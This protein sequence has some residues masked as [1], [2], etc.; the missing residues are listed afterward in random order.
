MKIKKIIKKIIKKNSELY[1]L[2]IKV[3]EL[4]ERTK[5]FFL[6]NYNDRLRRKY[7]SKQYK[8]YIGKK[9]DWNKLETYTEKMQWVKLYDEDRQKSILS[10][11]IEVRKWVENKIGAEYLIPLLGTWEKPNQIDFESLPAK[12][13]LKTNNASGT[14]IIV[15]DSSQINTKIVCAKLTRW[16]NVK[17]YYL[18]GF[19]MHYS[20]IKPLI[21]AEEYIEHGENDLQDYKFLC[22]NGK[23]YYCWVD[24]GRYHDHKRNMYDMDWNLQSWNE[25]N[26]R[27]YGN[28]DEPIEKPQN[29]EEMVYIVEKL[30]EGFSHVR[31][32]LYNV[33]GRVLFGEMTFTN[34]SGYGKIVPEEYDY[35]LGKIWDL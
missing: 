34:G 16:L 15:N 6:S 31:V 23:P 3:L 32:D 20:R 9:L 8:L 33:D 35:K 14:N 10:D 12:Y 5:V 22:F 2:G 18:S 17:A 29:F 13:V 24:V 26:R 25:W 30:C 11:K 19:E 1:R 28:T 4:S 21:L 27:D 7:I